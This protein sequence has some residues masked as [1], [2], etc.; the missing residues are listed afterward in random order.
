MRGKSGQA[1]DDAAATAKSNVL[2]GAGEG[3]TPTKGFDYKW[4]EFLPQTGENTISEYPG[5]SEWAMENLEGMTNDRF[6]YAGATGNDDML[7]VYDV[8]VEMGKAIKQIYNGETPSSSKIKIS[9]LSNGNH[10]A[11]FTA[12]VNEYYYLRHPLTGAKATSWSRMTNK[13]PREMIIAMSTETSSDGNSSYS[14][15]HSYIT[16]LAMQTFYND[17]LSSIN[18][19]GIETYNETPFYDFGST[20]SNGLDDADGR[21]NQKN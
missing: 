6:Y 9:S 11:R 21:E 14:K 12:F 20:M 19:F 15:I 16:Q 10:V 18:A 17:E 7:D 2:D 3:A 13:I 1:A 4:I 5:I 8:I